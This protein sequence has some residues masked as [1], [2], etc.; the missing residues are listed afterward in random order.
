MKSLFI[1][2]HFFL[3]Q[4]DNYQLHDNKQHKV[5]NKRNFLHF[6]QNFASSLSFLASLGKVCTTFVQ[7]SIR[8]VQASVFLKSSIVSKILETVSNSVNPFSSPF[9]SARYCYPLVAL[10]SFGRTKKRLSGHR[11]VVVIKV[12]LTRIRSV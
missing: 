2:F 10:L 12:S 5:I 7:E 8:C 6:S 3:S 1:F 4:C 11:Q 9:F